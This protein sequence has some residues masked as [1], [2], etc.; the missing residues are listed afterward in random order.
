MPSNRVLD[1][2]PAVGVAQTLILSYPCVFS[3]PI[4]TAVITS[5]FSSVGTPIV[6]VYISWTQS[7]SRL[8]GV[9]LIYSFYS[10]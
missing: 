3:T 6:L 9:D 7:L 2:G 1:S 10:W 5:T 8:N 4:S